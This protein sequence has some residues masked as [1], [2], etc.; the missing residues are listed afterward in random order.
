MAVGDHGDVVPHAPF[1]HSYR[2]GG[3]AHGVPLVRRRGGKLDFLTVGDGHGHGAQLGLVHPL[4]R[5]RIVRLPGQDAHPRV[6]GGP[7]LGEVIE[8]LDGI[9]R[10]KRLAV[11]GR[12]VHGDKV[13][14]RLG[15]GVAVKDHAAVPAGH[16]LLGEREV[17]APV[18]LSVRLHFQVVFVAALVSTI[19]SPPAMLPLV[20][21]RPNFQSA[22]T[23]SAED[24]PPRAL[25]PHNSRRR[26]RDQAEQHCAGQCS[27]NT[28][29]AAVI[30][31]CP[32]HPLRSLLMHIPVIG[33]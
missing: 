4:K 27:C 25:R 29:S 28:P 1:V 30:D 14:A 18:P 3:G 31:R 22:V 33:H 16:A 20:Y 15:P 26:R 17:F 19:R 9:A 23:Y 24:R 10:L 5:G 12:A 2:P 11:D 6:G 32:F 13:G 8:D 21:A 7:V